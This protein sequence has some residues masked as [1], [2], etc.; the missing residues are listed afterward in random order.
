M[1]EALQ[2]L[3]NSQ[4]QMPKI[5]ESLNITKKELMTPNSPTRKT[6]VEIKQPKENFKHMKAK[7]NYLKAHNLK[8]D[9]EKRKK[10]INSFKLD[11]T[12]QAMRNA[13][14]INIVK[15]KQDLRTAQ[16]LKD[17]KDMARRHCSTSPQRGHFLF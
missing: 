7:V 15:L 12:D 9:I 1:P 17:S 14:S 2:E 3:K 6:Q 8:I 11:T 16:H 4:Q 13:I 5:N 10:E